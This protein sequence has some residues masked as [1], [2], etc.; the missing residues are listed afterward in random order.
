MIAFIVILASSALL[1][2]YLVLVYCISYHQWHYYDHIM[3]QCTTSKHFAMSITSSYNT[4]NIINV[5]NK[6]VHGTC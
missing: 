4:F 3:T 6:P 2:E 5:I 1:Y